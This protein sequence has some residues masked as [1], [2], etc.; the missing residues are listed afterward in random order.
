MI[1]TSAMYTMGSGFPVNP[2]PHRKKLPRACEGGK[3][4]I[5]LSA[6]RRSEQSS[7]NFPNE[8]EEG[9][10]S[11]T[12]Q[13][14]ARLKRIMGRKGH[15]EAHTIVAPIGTDQPSNPRSRCSE[16]SCDVRVCM[17]ENTKGRMD[18][19]PLEL[20]SSSAGTDFETP[21]QQCLLNW[22]MDRTT[23]DGCLLVDGTSDLGVNIFSLEELVI[24]TQTDSQTS[25]SFAPSKTVFLHMS[26]KPEDNE[27]AKEKNKQF[28]PGGKGGRYRF[29]KWM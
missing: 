11:L 15:I 16:I 21:G 28:D 25:T 26:W 1:S 2:P 18:P 29:E 14:F 6:K 8:L 22:E 3:E 23:V 4:E 27:L 5:S 13:D 12:D 9:T 10:A 19:E 20:E 7:K 17:E 24:G